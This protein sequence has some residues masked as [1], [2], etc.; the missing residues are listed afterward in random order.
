MEAAREVGGLAGTGAP[1]LCPLRALGAKVGRLGSEAADGLHPAAQPARPQATAGGAGAKVA[2]P[3][4]AAGSQTF[5]AW[6][7]FN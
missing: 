5:S 7:A 1:G 3:I 4:S 6:T 2:L